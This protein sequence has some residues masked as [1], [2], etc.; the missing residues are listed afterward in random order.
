MRFKSRL[1]MCLDITTTYGGKY[2]GIGYKTR[3]DSANGLPRVFTLLHAIR[4]D[5]ALKISTG[6]TL[7]TRS[8]FGQLNMAFKREPPAPSVYPMRYES[9]AGPPMITVLFGYYEPCAGTVIPP[10]KERV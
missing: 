9:A 10:Q 6:G 1:K 3:K 8:V 4:L 7:R 5:F 2:K